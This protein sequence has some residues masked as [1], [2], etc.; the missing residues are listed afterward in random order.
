VNKSE[1]IDAISKD[2]SLSRN[3]AA[4]A[5][6]AFLATVS[7]A[8]KSGDE[9]KITGFG[10]FFVIKRAARTTRNPR[11]GEAIKVKASKAPRF[12]AG[13]VLKNAVAG[14]RK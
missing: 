10:R 8:L 5:L 14:R 9:V 7:K 11:T 1:L 2:S 12:T 4:K 3:D 6:D 13:A